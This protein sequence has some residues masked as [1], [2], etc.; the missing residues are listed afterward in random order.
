[1]LDADLSRLLA[2]KPLPR[3]WHSLSHARSWKGAIGATDYPD[4]AMEIETA[5]RYQAA[6]MGSTTG[7]S[8]SRLV[9]GAEGG[10]GGQSGGDRVP[11]SDRGMEGDDVDGECECS[12][13]EV[14][15]ECVSVQ[16]CE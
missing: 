2:D 14:S 8:P 3:V 1:M 13:S 15:G 12:V 11:V 6:S 7:A 10:G 4:L 5:D 9:L 16:R